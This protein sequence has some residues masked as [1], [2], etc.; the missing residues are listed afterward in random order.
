MFVG[1]KN[2]LKYLNKKYKSDKSEMVVLYGR[3]RIGKTELIREFLKDK[4]FVFYAAS[5]V[6]DYD[7]LKRFSRVIRDKLGLENIKMSFDSWDDLFKSIKKIKTSKKLVVAIDEFPYMVNGNKS[8][9]SLLQNL[10]DHEI[11]DLNILFIFTGSSVGIM[12]DD[13]LGSNNPL[14]GRIS[15]SYK[16]DELPIQDLKSFFPDY[17]NE[18]I[19]TT[20]SILG[21]VPQYLLCFDPEL[22]VEDNIKE[23]ILQKGAYLYDEVQMLMKQE[24]REATTYFTILEAIAMGNTKLNQIYQMTQIEKTKITTYLGRLIQLDIIEREHPVTEKLK[25]KVNVQ[26]GLYQLK[27]NYF[28]FYFRYLFPSNSLLELKAVDAVYNNVIKEDLNIHVSQVF[29]KVC[30]EYV[31]QKNILGE[32]PVFAMNCGRWWHKQEEIDIVAFDGKNQYVFGECKWR[33]EKVSIKILEQLQ[34]KISRNFKNIE[35]VKI[36]L[37]SKSGFES[38]LIDYCKADVRIELIDITE[39]LS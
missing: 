11:K 38:K 1:R 23:N 34:A 26:S 9:P 14:Y 5:E 39:L 12:L 19:I 15:G 7:Q 17:S 25:K 2:E 32:L 27:N 24:L 16:L 37:F 28:R 33:N 3:R 18:D 10:W 30:V 21:G 20:Y 6:D 31:M 8:I 35:I 36:F 4:D 22:S 29:E 13:I